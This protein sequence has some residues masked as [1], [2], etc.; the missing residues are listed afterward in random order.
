MLPNFPSCG[1]PVAG[2]LWLKLWRDVLSSSFCVAPH[3]LGSYG[4][5]GG[6][7]LS[8]L[9]A[10]LGCAPTTA[11]RLLQG[12]WTC[13]V[14]SP[15]QGFIFPEPLTTTT[16]AHVLLRSLTCLSTPPPKCL[17]FLSLLYSETFWAPLN[18]SPLSVTPA[19]ILV[20]CFLLR[21]CYTVW[22][23]HSCR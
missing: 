16:D 9:P 11:P 8:S 6:G 14:C 1:H 4:S 23:V 22:S 3:P 21:V 20:L 12:S 10:S 7:G 13:L 18:Q 15:A 5:Q 19:I 17:P 2:F